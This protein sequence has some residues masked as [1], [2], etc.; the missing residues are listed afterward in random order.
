MSEFTF[1]DRAMHFQ[2]GI[3]AVLDEKK[4]RLQNKEG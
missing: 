1:S 2:A 3:F 4:R